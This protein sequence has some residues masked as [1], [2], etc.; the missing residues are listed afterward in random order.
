MKTRNLMVFMTLILFLATTQTALAYHADL[1]PIITREAINLLG[2][3]E[4]NSLYVYLH[5]NLGFKNGLG[6][7]FIVSGQEGS[8]NKPETKRVIEQ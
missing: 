7:E 5:N 2:E 3:G 1:H 4:N 8:L 6:E